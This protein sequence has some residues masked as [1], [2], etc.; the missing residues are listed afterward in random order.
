MGESLEKTATVLVSQMQANTRP[1]AN[2]H[3]FQLEP[4]SGLFVCAR[5]GKA[6]THRIRMLACEGVTLARSQSIVGG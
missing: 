2:G 4:H 1:P 6:K 5:C 3:D